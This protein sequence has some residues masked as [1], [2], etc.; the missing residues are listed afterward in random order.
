MTA[1]GWATPYLRRK[2]LDHSN[3]VATFTP[4]STLSLGFTYTV[5]PVTASTLPTGYEVAGSGYARTT[6][7][8]DGTLWNAADAAGSAT[9]KLLVSCFTASANW[10]TAALGWFIIDASGNLWT[11]GQLVESDLVT[12][13]PMLPSLGQ[14]VTFPP[15]S[16]IRTNAAPS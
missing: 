11:A 5:L 15:D 9:N 10:T 7:A 8:N 1:I 3:G 13:K 2:R 16:L 4:P 6:V 12:A 14:I